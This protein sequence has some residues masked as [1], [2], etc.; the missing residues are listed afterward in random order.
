MYEDQI[1][2]ISVFGPPSS[3]HSCNDS[4]IMSVNIQ[5]RG[6]DYLNTGYHNI[7]LLLFEYV[8]IQECH[9]QNQ[10]TGLSVNQVFLYYNIE[11]QVCRMSID[12]SV[13]VIHQSLCTENLR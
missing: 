8:R 3:N 1:A 5:C 9:I 6:N 13:L 11:I 10:N 12:I 7:L 2:R 4:L